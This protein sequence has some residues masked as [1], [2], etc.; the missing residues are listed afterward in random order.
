MKSPIEVQNDIS[1]PGVAEEVIALN[2]FKPLEGDPVKKQAGPAPEEVIP[3]DQFKPQSIDREDLANYASLA[4][5]AANPIGFVY[6]DTLPYSESEQKWMHD[7]LPLK[8]KEE[9]EAGKKV[10]EQADS[11]VFGKMYYYDPKTA[12]PKILGTNENIPLDPTS[13]SAVDLHGGSAIDR[14]ML[15]AAGYGA[16]GASIGAMVG[17]WGMGVGAVPG[18]AV[19]GTIGAIIGAGVNIAD[20]ETDWISREDDPLLEEGVF[21]SMVKSFNNTLLGSLPGIA[22][23]AKLGSEGIMG[24]ETA[25]SD[26]YTEMSRRVAAGEKAINPLI[27]QELQSEEAYESFGAFFDPENYDASAVP[28]FIAQAAASMSQFMGTGLGVKMAAGGAQK[29]LAKG[30]TKYAT[31]TA[32]KAARVKAMQTTAKKYM[33]QGDEILAKKW[34]QKAAKESGEN[35]ASKVQ[36]MTAGMMINNSEIMQSLDEATGLSI[37]EKVAYGMIA[38]IGMGAIEMLGGPDAAALK[39]LLSS[40]GATKLIMNEVVDEVRKQT[41]KKMTGKALQ[42]VH[43]K[44]YSSTLKRV[45][46]VM[47]A[48]GLT[49][50]PEGAEELGQSAW[51]DAAKSMANY[52]YETDDD[53]G[54]NVDFLSPETWTEYFNSF[55]AGMAGGTMG[56]SS[57]MVK[58]ARMKESMFISKA[59]ADKEYEVRFRQQLALYANKRYIGKRQYENTIKNLDTFIAYNKATEDLNLDRGQKRDLFV[60]LH[61]AKILQTKIDELTATNLPIS[62]ALKKGLARHQSI[63]DKIVNDPES[64]NKA[65]Q[66]KAMKQAEKQAETAKKEEAEKKKKKEALK[67]EEEKK[68]DAAAQ[69][70]TEEELEDEEAIRGKVQPIL[71]RDTV[72]ENL[73]ENAAEIIEETIKNPATGAERPIFKNKAGTILKGITSVIREIKPE[74]DMVKTA[75]DT[76]KNMYGKKKNSKVPDNIDENHPEVKDLIDQWEWQRTSGIGIHAVVEDVINGKDLKEVLK[77]KTV[78]EQSQITNAYNIMNDVIGKL[79]Q[80][81]SEF[82]TEQKIYDE[83]T[84]TILIADLLRVNADGSVDIFDFKVKTDKKGT[85]EVF[86]KVDKWTQN[87]RKAIPN[88]KAT[89][90]A[91]YGVQ[92]KMAKRVLEERGIKVNSTQIIPIVG[93]INTNETEDAK[94]VKT[95]QR[96]WKDQRAGEFID[97]GESLTE[98]DVS[99]VRLY[100]KKKKTGK[101]AAAKAKKATAKPQ[102]N[103][104]SKEIILDA[105]YNEFIDKGILTQERLSSIAEKV[106]NNEV[107]TPRETKIFTDKTS[108]INKIIAASVTAQPQPA[109]AAIAQ[110]PTLKKVKVD[111]TGL[112][113]DEL[114]NV[115]KKLRQKAINARASEKQGQTVIG[116][117]GVIESDYQ[118]V[119]A[120]IAELEKSAQPQPAPAATLNK[121]FN[122]REL[123]DKIIASKGPQAKIAKIILDR[124]NRLNE[125]TT[126]GVLDGDGFGYAVTDFDTNGNK[127]T[128]DV[129]INFDNIQKEIKQGN[130]EPG[131]MQ[132]TVVHEE[133]HRY[134]TLIFRI[135]NHVN[136]G[137]GSY[138]QFGLTPDEVAFAEAATQLYEQYLLHKNK[139]EYAFSRL[140]ALTDI[141]EFVAY[142]LTNPEFMQVLEK[143]KVSPTTSLLR[144]LVDAIK[145]L[146]GN[147]PN[148][149]QALERS[150]SAF[151][152]NEDLLMPKLDKDSVVVIGSRKVV[153]TIKY[154]QHE[155]IVL[156]DHTILN[157]DQKEV[158]KPDTVGGLSPKTGKPQF[159]TRNK[160]LQMAGL[161]HGKHN[162]NNHKPIIPP[163]AKPQKPSNKLAQPRQEYLKKVQETPFVDTASEFV[164]YNGRDYVKFESTG[165]LFP[166]EMN[167]AKHSMY[168]SARKQHAGEKVYLRYIPAAEWNKDQ[169]ITQKGTGIPYGD[170]IQIVTENGTLLGH[171]EAT[172]VGASLNAKVNF[173]EGPYAFDY[174]TLM[175]EQVHTLNQG[176]K[177]VGIKSYKTKEL[178][179][180][181][182]EEF[183]NAFSLPPQM[184]Y[185]SGKSKKAK[186]EMQKVMP[187]INFVEAYIQ[188]GFNLAKEA[189]NVAGRKLHAAQKIAWDRIVEL[190][191]ADNITLPDAARQAFYAI[192]TSS[193]KSASWSGVT[194][195]YT[196]LL[197]NSDLFEHVVD[198]MFYGGEQSKVDRWV[199]SREVKPL[200]SGVEG[201]HS[202]TAYELLYD[203][204]HA[205]END[206]RIDYEMWINDLAKQDTDL[207]R[208]AQNIIENFDISKAVTLFNIIR[209]SKKQPYFELF[210]NQTITLQDGSK[211]YSSQLKVVN[212]S[213]E[214]FFSVAGMINDHKTA[215][216]AKWGGPEYEQKRNG[217]TVGEYL[218]QL[219]NSKHAS[220]KEAL[221]A[222]IKSYNYSPKTVFII[223]GVKTLGVK[224]A[225]GNII[226]GRSLAER[227]LA[228]DLEIVSK[229]TGL[230]VEYLEVYMSTI[231]GAQG[232]ET[233]IDAVMDNY[234]SKQTANNW[235]VKTDLDKKTEE[236]SVMHQF[237]SERQMMKYYDV[238]YKS[239]VY[240]DDYESY[241]KMLNDNGFQRKFSEIFSNTKYAPK[242]YGADGEAKTSAPLNNPVGD[243][244]ARALE[245]PMVG[246]YA[247]NKVLEYYH[248]KGINI[249]IMLFNGIKSVAASVGVTGTDLSDSDKL[250]AAVHG[251]LNTNNS[252][253]G[254]DEYLHWLGQMGDRGSHM[255]IP[256]K[257]YANIKGEIE[258][259]RSSNHPDAKH[260]PSNDQFKADI[261]QIKERLDS[262]QSNNLIPR[263][264]NGAKYTSK[265]LDQLAKEISGNYA[266]NKYYTDQIF[267]GRIDNYG[268][269]AAPSQTLTGAT[270]NQVIN[271]AD[272]IKI[273]KN[274]ITTNEELEIFNELKPY[275]EAQGSK[276]NKATAAPIMIGLGLRWDYTSNNPGKTPI[277]VGETINNSA[278]QKN[279]Y[280]YYDVAHNGQPLGEI[281]QK[282]KDL[283]SRAT[284]IDASNYDGAIINVYP[285]NGFISAHNDVDESVTAINYPVLVLN[286]GGNGSLSVEG[287]ESQNAKKSY[288]NKEYTDTKLNSGDAYI[289][290]ENGINRDVF[291]RTLPSSGKGTLPELNIQGQIIPAN[292]YRITITLRRVMPLTANMA[293][294]PSQTLPAV[295]SNETIKTGFQGYKGGYQNEGKGT[296][297]GDGKD[298]AMRRVADG[299][300]GEHKPVNTQTSTRTSFN[301][302]T[303]KLQE[304]EGV[305]QGNSNYA[306]ETQ[307]IFS[308]KYEKRYEGNSGKI[309]TIGVFNN[310]KVVMLA[311]NEEYK[312]QELNDNTKGLILEAYNQGAEF[313]VGDMPGVD[314]Q[315]I[316]YLQEIGAKFTVYHTGATPLINV[317]ENITTQ[318]EEGRKVLKSIGIDFTNSNDQNNQSADKN[319]ISDFVNHSGGAEGYDTEWDVIGAKFGMVNNKHYLLPSDGEVAS[320]TLKAK[321]VKPVDA[322]N[323]VG[324][325]STSGPAISEAQIA[326]TNAERAMGRIEPTHTTRNT[327]KIRN[328]AQV[329]NADAIFA[330]GSL[331][332][333]G[334]DITISKG[335]VTKKA[336]LPQVNGGTSVAVQLGI[337]MN[338]PTYVFN[339]VKNTAY[340]IGWYKWDDEVQN[341]TPISTP[342]L[343]KNFAGIGTSSNTTAIGKKAIE[344][345]YKATKEAL[346]KGI[347]QNTESADTSA[348]KSVINPDKENAK[349]IKNFFKRLATFGSGGVQPT[350]GIPGGLKPTYNQVIIQDHTH[351]YA[352]ESAL[353]NSKIEFDVADGFMFQSEKH[354][355]ELQVSI[356]TGINLGTSLK[357]HV[358]YVKNNGDPILDKGHRITLT[359]ELAE[360]NPKVLMPLYLFMTQYDVDVISWTGTSKLYERTDIN[361]NPINV[362]NEA[363]W[364]DKGKMKSGELENIKIVSRDSSQIRV[365]LD[366]NKDIPMKKKRVAPQVIRHLKRIVGHE[367]ADSLI[368]EIVT[369]K[370][371]DYSHMLDTI[372]ETEMHQFL[373]DQMSD[374]G[375]TDN[376]IELL[377]N[378]VALS[379]PLLSKYLETV[380]STNVK[381]S[382][383]D[384]RV[385]GNLYTSIPASMFDADLRGPR[386][387]N[388]KV[389]P[390]ECLVPRSSGL[391]ISDVILVARMPADDLHSIAMVKVRGYL[392]DSAGNKIVMDAVSSKIAGED[393]DGDQRHIWAPSKSTYVND[394]TETAKSRLNVENQKRARHNALYEL[395]ANNY[396]HYL[397]NINKIFADAPNFVSTDATTLASEFSTYQEQ[398]IQYLRNLPNTV[399][400]MDIF[401]SEI[402]A[403]VLPGSRRPMT[404]YVNTEAAVMQKLYE[405]IIKKYQ[406]PT[407]YDRITNPV[408]TE[409]M[410]SQMGDDEIG[411]INKNLLSSQITVYG[412]NKSTNG[413]GN[414]ISIVAKV[415]STLTEMVGNDMHMRTTTKNKTTDEESLNE[416]ITLLG[417][418]L[419]QSTDNGKLMNL[420]RMK[421][422][423]ANANIWLTMVVKGYSLVEIRKFMDNKNVKYIFDH[424]ARSKNIEQSE[425]PVALSRIL[426]QYKSQATR[427]GNTKDVKLY[428]L[429]ESFLK[430]SD[431]LYSIGKMISATEDGLP[432]YA[433]FYEAM[434]IQEKLRQS[435]FEQV[436]VNP[437]KASLIASF[438]TAM[439]ISRKAQQLNNPMHTIGMQQFVHEI[440]KSLIKSRKRK[441]V[442][443]DSATRVLNKKQV[444][445]LDRAATRFLEIRY[446]NDY[447]IPATELELLEKIRLREQELRLAHPKFFQYIGV[448]DGMDNMMKFGIRNEYTHNA[449]PA[450]LAEIADAFQ[451]L[452]IDFQNTIIQ[453]QGIKYGLVQ[454]TKLGGYASAIPHTQAKQIGAG[455][456]ALK[457]KYLSEPLSNA[458]KAFMLASE[459][460]IGIKRNQFNKKSKVVYETVYQRGNR[461]PSISFNGP[462]GRVEIEANQVQ[463]L[464]LQRIAKER[465]AEI[466]DKS[467]GSLGPQ[468]NNI[469]AGFKNWFGTRSNNLQGDANRNNMKTDAQIANDLANFFSSTGAVDLKSMTYDDVKHYIDGNM[470]NEIR[471]RENLNNTFRDDMHYHFYGKAENKD[472]NVMPTT[473]RMNF[474]NP[475]DEAAYDQL[476]NIT[477]P[478]LEIKIQWE[479]KLAVPNP[480][481]L[482]LLENE[483]YNELVY[484]QQLER[485][486]VIK[487]YPADKMSLTEFIQANFPQYGVGVNK[488]FDML[489][490][491]AQD[492]IHRAYDGR[493]RNGNGYIAG[494]YAEEFYALNNEKDAW[495]GILDNDLTLNDFVDTE[496]LK[497]LQDAIDRLQQAYKTKAVELPLKILKDRLAKELLLELVRQENTFNTKQRNIYTRGL[498]DIVTNATNIDW[499]GSKLTSGTASMVS[500]SRLE[501]GIM[502]LNEQLIRERKRTAQV[503]T[504]EMRDRMNEFEKRFKETGATMAMIT[505]PDRVDN[506]D[507]SQTEYFFASNSPEYLA[508]VARASSG[509]EAAK[510]LVDFMNYHVQQDKATGNYSWD[511]TQ[512][513]YR[514]PQVEADIFALLFDS[515]NFKNIAKW[516]EIVKS[517]NLIKAVESKLASEKGFDNYTINI[518][519][520]GIDF[521]AGYKNI[522]HASFSD[523]KA[524]LMAKMKGGKSTANILHDVKILRNVSKLQAIAEQMHDAGVDDAGMPTRN[525]TRRKIKPKVGFAKT[526]TTT[527]DVF[528]AIKQHHEGMIFKEQFEAV[529]PLMEMLENHVEGSAKNMANWLRMHNN[530]VLYGEKTRSFMHEHPVLEKSVRLLI[531]FTY[532]KMMG[533]NWLG[534]VFNVTQ[535]FTQT[536]R[537]QGLKTTIKGT[538]R[539]MQLRKGSS[540]QETFS[541]AIRMMNKFDIVN[542]SKDT[543]SNITTKTFDTA[544]NILFMNITIPEYLNH[545]MS[546]FGQ[547][548]DAEWSA[549]KTLP[550]NSTRHDYLKALGTANNVP[551]GREEEMGQN[552]IDELQDYTQLINGAYST[553]SRRHIN[554]TIEGQAVTMFKNWLPELYFAHFSKEFNDMYGRN[555]KGM[556]TSVFDAVKH[557][558]KIDGWKEFAMVMNPIGLPAA[559]KF[560][561][562]PE[563]DQLNIRKLIR[564]LFI[565]A[566]IY[567]TILAM[568]DDDDDKKKEHR[569]AVTLLDRLMNETM[570]IYVPGEYVNIIDSGIPIVGTVKDLYQMIY[571]GL[572]M[573]TY[574]ATYGHREKGDLKAAHMVEKNIP[575]ISRGMNFYR[576]IDGLINE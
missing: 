494:N 34:F 7:M 44:A 572:T 378:G 507:G 459:P 508:I 439:A 261:A 575:G 209:S 181:G 532:L 373:I 110:A 457:Q 311:R 156:D 512:K 168:Q 329:K 129:K 73:K 368:R 87:F 565:M 85:K 86:E 76:V 39:R 504:G 97:L 178:S 558:K 159:N 354:Q 140:Y 118:A 170:K 501:E 304:K 125:N 6:N 535:G 141:S 57:D 423:T 576:T 52:F 395:Y 37:R 42:Q 167:L 176:S 546:F 223:N 396:M 519:N 505:D 536:V 379:Y 573:E 138:E 2:E 221:R 349:K 432:S 45:V 518:E 120:Y 111:L 174:S 387:Y 15:G 293:K 511:E 319:K 571:F 247:G 422:N 503:E 148:M 183:N 484:M 421:L 473:R 184:N 154:G 130:A 90:S 78:E 241:F 420:H 388:G 117:S 81:G 258:A 172:G 456:A 390:G 320:A 463:K 402:P 252:L 186:N 325:V 538:Y 335:L 324:V 256:A 177:M 416:I 425:T 315:F 427:D 468:I 561:L 212:K 266:I 273:I 454:S 197:E 230:N 527:E 548:T 528:G 526:N 272:G 242:F 169:S 428:S 135:F 259:I 21:K 161:L 101:A 54:Y 9:I 35:V 124:M 520:T 255:T 523:L 269:D 108:E 496:G 143:I 567:L 348:K 302:I 461:N 543:E 522:T 147:D 201:L 356:G 244:A 296:Y 300:I 545:G 407:N 417:D 404:K 190:H 277:E 291:H 475:N 282:I 119:K 77:G 292:S 498:Y 279:K 328:Y 493:D 334:A 555:R 509:D 537:E 114:K 411:G 215:M 393:Y 60:N 383:L 254:T 264:D 260:F 41:G 185:I 136:K 295:I 424:L 426:Q 25:F 353:K 84:D 506:P 332:P 145:A 365:L 155:Y 268:K 95:K 409:R 284:G 127:R 10:F 23:I 307:D 194:P 26:I 165:E 235:Y 152:Y 8:Q 228:I 481:I 287:A 257:K 265:E 500:P 305:R 238:N 442:K 246:Y 514:I 340:S 480:M 374:S 263:K 69:E 401:K 360:E 166:V 75:I 93:Q 574:K 40:T 251:Y 98:K 68:Q 106:K 225:K 479:K 488:T 210:V 278:Y 139:P 376:L 205:P 231:Y 245:I 299:F 250:L 157:K 164:I 552:R 72:I 219:A 150:F 318:T 414:V 361:D 446:F 12:M 53:S 58:A 499:S 358:A 74:M 474:A 384:L 146:F 410:E 342:L 13:G 28:M 436:E 3:I 371:T 492:K 202:S 344:D 502:Q 99:S 434:A 121:V 489:S 51:Q 313:V 196:E 303:F 460:E 109:P 562:L 17:A 112:S 516:L 224:D 397:P 267:F 29:L 79:R 549:I 216:M 189:I 213:K 437:Y 220:M 128:V 355:Q 405:E 92:L 116:G 471:D 248:E 491:E 270:N 343:T 55:A 443:P 366:L 399:S 364:D 151:M 455:I 477:I 207:G 533:G 33:A 227:Q 70:F 363:I 530:Y 200:Y 525:D 94:G 46:E 529:Q 192:T 415:L 450:M 271:V 22:A 559:Q 483:L 551:A 18:A 377:K 65:Q 27:P 105:E 1:N 195:R 445:A 566:G 171:I 381:K 285:K 96:T 412:A 48:G 182:N 418:T 47:K 288:A 466:K 534:S 370:M 408:N 89:K 175:Q 239:Y 314:S 14:M 553:N 451:E 352:I 290:G 211:S 444:E 198:E 38:T 132:E 341:F 206:G 406:D 372:D 413:R 160:I 59:A 289:F 326:V 163:G 521:G 490:I 61:E 467:S 133:I 36:Q 333:K 369:Q 144:R 547:M 400:T 122:T 359:K 204:I 19:G 283:I 88:K 306:V 386:I 276:T 134:T 330:I 557:L 243:R 50:L 449:N 389:L 550:E 11:G 542:T 100:M 113:I 91:E 31:Y 286:I 126:I 391:E 323:D 298:Q 20:P 433:D 142:G 123:L 180:P 464:Y 350:I 431:E 62:N 232:Y 569:T 308:K 495:Q 297:N 301:E 362:V 82:L 556:I 447:Y 476:I 104:S 346:K 188:D 234:G 322:T 336:L 385:R 380:I 66:K 5:N 233:F 102:S 486:N 487:G 236:V 531:S 226:T 193:H 470:T 472:I 316:D 554:D 208:V 430:A 310:P 249:P 275:L 162:P 345:V 382:V 570:F 16:S 568:W 441:G 49:A 478:E 544:Q 560:A 107:L 351:K 294:S 222:D 469:N 321:G 240:N 67:K 149:A 517:S 80:P 43:N 64:K 203:E 458:D 337:T 367:F 540:M 392:P 63:I 56:G 262:Y 4:E 280:R 465:Q 510:V 515:L 137:N 30:S 173:I 440:E 214:N 539:F 115:A 394:N 309:E 218:M 435:K 398:M 199:N 513:R 438:E 331:I 83:E 339:Q 448:Y 131:F 237:A 274:T 429:F 462:K 217:R 485:D 338:K 103:T 71:Y 403:D 563:A 153:A 312:G 281:S 357:A 564:E 497:G 419:N 158:W 327:K 375:N 229:L 347:T 524:S 452:P 453:Y 32:A 482:S 187:H 541:A 24:N 253:T 317:A 191:K 179:K